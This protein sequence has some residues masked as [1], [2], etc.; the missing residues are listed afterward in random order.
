MPPW[1]RERGAQRVVS[2]IACSEWRCGAEQRCAFDS[3]PCLGWGETWLRF[4]Q[5]DDAFHPFEIGVRRRLGMIGEE[6]AEKAARRAC[7][8]LDA[9]WR[10]ANDDHRVLMLQ[11]AVGQ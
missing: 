11:T 9:D 1:R 3:P 10:L 4:R 8:R 2:Q 5:L 6:L 7:I